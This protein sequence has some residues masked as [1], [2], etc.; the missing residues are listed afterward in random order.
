M[1]ETRIGEL[2]RARGWTQERLA[3]ESGIAVRTIQRLEAGS[4]ASLDT[5]SRIAAALEV[6]VSS[7][8]AHVEDPEFATAVDGL[9]ERIAAQQARRDAITDATRKAFYG[10]GVV[11]SLALAALVGARLL[12]GIAFFLVAIY[13][14]GGRVAYDLL[15]RTVIDP[16][17]DAQ[18]PLSGPTRGRHR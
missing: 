7:L 18:Y 5:L 14:V 8:F 4:D 17:L 12:P 6:E 13:W 10:L 2:R 11:I 15:L 1:N 3:A 9:G 16:R